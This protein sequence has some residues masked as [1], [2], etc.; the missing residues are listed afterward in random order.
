M[1]SLVCSLAVAGLAIAC[2]SNAPEGFANKSMAAGGAPNEPT[3]GFVT[4]EGPK[5]TNECQKM[6]IVFVVDDSGSMQEEQVNLAQN[7]PRFIDVL[8]EYESKS[9]AKLDYRVAVTTSGVSSRFKVQTPLGTISQSEKGMDGAFRMESSCRS[10]RRW[11]ERSDPNPD[12][13]FACEA[14]VGTKGPGNEMPL[15]ALKLALVD[16]MQDG[17]NAGFLRPDALLAVV[18]M[19]DEDDC[20][21][22]DNDYVVDSFSTCDATPQIQPVADY[23]AMLDQVAGGEGRWALT[24]IAGTGPGS[25]QSV[26]GEAEEATR[27]KKLVGMSGKNA[28]ITSICG[29]DLS[30]ALEDALKNFDGACKTFGVR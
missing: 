18:I 4:Q 23:K 26:F 25:C 7:F 16:R 8:D 22:R 20:S 5:E 14:Q 13:T 24:V 15:E 19:T 2:G 27:L 11:V 10:T 17:T 30:I 12:R 9:G 3:S 29:G 1:R 6:D 21:R 28:N